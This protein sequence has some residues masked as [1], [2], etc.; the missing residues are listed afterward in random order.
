M[1]ITRQQLRKLIRESIDEN[2]DAMMVA[3]LNAW[4]DN[5]VSNISYC[6]KTSFI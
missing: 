3:K 2:E 6:I 4:I 1:K 5:I